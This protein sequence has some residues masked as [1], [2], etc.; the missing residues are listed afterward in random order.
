VRVLSSVRV[1]P[2]LALAVL[3]PSP[4]YAQRKSEALPPGE[5]RIFRDCA[6]CPEMLALPPGEFLMGSPESERGRGS[7]EGPQHKV[8]MPPFAMGKFEVTFAQWDLCASE[9]G[10]AYKPADEGWGRGRRPVINVSWDDPRQFVAWIAK[11]TGKAYRL[12][13]E[14]EWVYAARGITRTSEPHPP[15]STGATINYKQ[16]NYDANFTYGSGQMGVFRQKSVDVGSFQMNAFGLHDV[17]GNVW[18]GSR[19]ATRKSTPARPPTG[20]PLA[21]K[22]ACAFCAAGPGTTTPSSCAPPIATRRLPKYV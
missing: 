13:S 17:H 4:G 15:F 2:T 10:C 22:I 12:P 6:G 16:A 3:L 9:G 1:L 21:L 18:S 11:K 14:A 8:V 19:I 20:H 5:V 7:N